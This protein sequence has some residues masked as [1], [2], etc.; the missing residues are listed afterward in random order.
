[1]MA[2]RIRRYE[3]GVPVPTLAVNGS[4]LFEPW[5]HRRP[6]PQSSS[7]KT[8]AFSWRLEHDSGARVPSPRAQTMACQ[9]GN[10][11]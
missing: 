8:V 2:A 6:P 3:T 9:E 11:R 7:D 4:E 5:R 10:R 1:M